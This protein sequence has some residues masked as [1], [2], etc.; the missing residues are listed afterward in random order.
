MRIPTRHKIQ[1]FQKELLTWYAANGRHHFNWRKPEMTAYNIIIAEVLLQRTSASKVQQFHADFITSYPNWKSIIEAGI[2]KVEHSFRPLGLFRQRAARLMSLAVAMQ[3]MGKLPE[4]PSDLEELPFF[5]Q[6]LTY[7]VQ[8]QVYGMKRPLL[9]LNMARVL[10]RRFG[11]RKKS[12][13]RYDTNLQELAFAVVDSEDSVRLSWAILD[14]ASAV[15]RSGKPF[16]HSCQLS[17]GCH[18]F[19]SL[20]K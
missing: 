15:C 1:Q 17:K 4:N 12:D 18:F 13:I 20:N 10:E 7:A 19:T 5:G 6:Y 16:C 8:L 9:D 11:E 14:F 2:E 3:E